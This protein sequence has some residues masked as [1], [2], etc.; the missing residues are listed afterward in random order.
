MGKD[1]YDD[2]DSDFKGDLKSSAAEAYERVVAREP[3]TDQDAKITGPLLK[4]L[5]DRERVPFLMV[6]GG[7]ILGFNEILYPYYL[8]GDYVRQLAQNECISAIELDSGG[9]IGSGGML[10]SGNRDGNYDSRDGDDGYDWETS[11]QQAGYEEV[12]TLNDRRLYLTEIKRLED[13]GETVETNDDLAF[14]KKELGL[15]TYQGRIKSAD[16]EADKIRQRVSQNI[17]NWYK[18]MEGE[19]YGNDE[20]RIIMAHFRNHIRTGHDCYYT[21]GWKFKFF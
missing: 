1:E 9:A 2:I 11:N 12:F 6:R 7:F 10:Y 16:P 13:Q 8:G 20:S 14:Y 19:K 15:T 18:K 21:P 4:K 3:P 17:Y 5:A